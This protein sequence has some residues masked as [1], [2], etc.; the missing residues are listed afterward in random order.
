M[1]LALTWL[2]LIVTSAAMNCEA[3]N[4]LGS[5]PYVG[6]RRQ[7]SCEQKII[8]NAQCHI[9]YYYDS[10]NDWRRK[11]NV[12]KRILPEKKKNKNQHEHSHRY[13]EHITS[14]QQDIHNLTLLFKTLKR[15][16]DGMHETNTT[17][18]NNYEHTHITKLT[19]QLDTLKREKKEWELKLR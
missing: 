8:C 7:L 6:Q 15:E 14:L 1:R 4:Q 13:V 12:V 11:N 19:L 3:V 10:C 2:F 16:N 18:V 9:G 5:C 17:T